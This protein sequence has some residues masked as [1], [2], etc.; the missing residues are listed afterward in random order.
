V[1]IRKWD[2]RLGIRAYRAI[3]T[4]ASRDVQNNTASPEFGRFFHPIRRELGL[5]FVLGK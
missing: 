3:G 4:S 5:V 1:R 2:V